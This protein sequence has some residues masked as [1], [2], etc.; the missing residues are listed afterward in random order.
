MLG[1]FDGL[2]GVAEFDGDV[3]GVDG[4]VRR[5]E[6][7]AVVVAVLPELP[8]DLAGGVEI[9]MGPGT[10]VVPRG[11]DGEDQVSRAVEGQYGGLGFAVIF[12]SSA[13]AMLA[14]TWWAW[15]TWPRARN[16]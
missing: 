14:A 7:G 5:A 12:G 2:S 16:T 4:D 1:E 3:D 6:L 8:G 13:A 10:L 11:D 9:L 15:S